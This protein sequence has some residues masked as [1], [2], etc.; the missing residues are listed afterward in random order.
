MHAMFRE[1]IKCLRLATLGYL[2][3]FMV[4]PAYAVSEDVIKRIEE[5]LD[6][7]GRSPQA[8]GY[9]RRYDR[10]RS[11]SPTVSDT[12]KLR[13]LDPGLRTLG[14]PDAGN[15][16]ALRAIDKAIEQEVLRERRLP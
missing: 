6:R 16:R 11:D 1:M 9:Q 8:Y 15:S 12:P 4:Q 3:T 5:F 13:Q 10:D 7:E 2:L 14:T